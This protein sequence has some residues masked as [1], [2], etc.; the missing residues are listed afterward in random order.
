MRRTGQLTRAGAAA[1]MAAALAACLLPTPSHAQDLTLIGVMTGADHQTYR[2]VPFRVPAGVTAVTVEFAYTGREQKSVI[3]LGLRDPQRFRGWSGGAKAR[4]TVSETWATPSYLPGPL[5]AGTWRLILGVP[6]LRKDARAEYTA[7]ISFERNGRFQGFAEAPLKTGPGWYRGDLHLH[8]A[9]SDGSCAAQS[10]KRAP[11]PLYRTLEAAA[12]RGLDFVAVTE[13][14][15]TSHHQA[16]AELQPAFDRLLLIPGREITT[17]QGHA[18]VFGATAPLDFQLGGPRAPTLDRILDQAEAAGALASINHPG[19]PSGEACMGCGWTAPASDARIAAVEAVNGGNAVGLAFWEARLNEGRR[20]TAI[21]G[22]DN[23]DA[24]LDLARAPAVGVPTTVVHAENLSQAAI[25][26][27]LRA[28]HAFVD[29]AGSRD[30]L[31]DVTAR[32]GSASA[33]MGDVLR[34]P[35]GERVKV[36]VRLKGVET[37]RL[38]YAGPL[39]ARIREAGVGPLSADETRTLILVG[40]QPL[41]GWL[42][43]D[44]RGPD[45]R[46]WLLGNPIYLE[47]APSRP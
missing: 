6:N 34:I 19:L 24:T 21:G 39:A 44:V 17:F 14:N 5:P 30:R 43:I 4:F 18:N 9:H 38:A 13:H 3:D 35:A 16:L 32:A 15:T 36:E 11:C 42:R 37:G 7:K 41:S 1:G 22:S 47:P 20:V 25:L 26:D 33:R 40:E 8:T 12:A 2:E 10:G 27:A 45:G 46:L 31:L 23:H 28:G 29:L